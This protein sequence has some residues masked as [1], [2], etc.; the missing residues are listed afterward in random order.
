MTPGKVFL[1]LLAFV[2]SGCI[3]FNKVADLAYNGQKLKSYKES[4]KY[5]GT[6]KRKLSNGNIEMYVVMPVTDDYDDKIKDIIMFSVKQHCGDG[7]KIEAEE[8][9]LHGAF[10][11]D[12]P[13]Q[14]MVVSQKVVIECNRYAN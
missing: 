8:Q 9:V 6:T 2:L 7:F 14:W 11:A 4:R 3:S 13:N 12:L 5:F 10:G 1:S